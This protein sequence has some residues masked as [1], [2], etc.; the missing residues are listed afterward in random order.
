VKCTSQSSTLSN[1]ARTRT[2]MTQYAS[3]LNE[4]RQPSMYLRTYVCSN[5]VW[6]INRSWSL[7]D[8]R[9]SDQIYS[10]HAAISILNELNGIDSAGSQISVSGLAKAVTSDCAVPLWLSAALL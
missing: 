1:G 9:E 10:V 4:L 6:D 5:V 3:T 7:L 2:V 8:V